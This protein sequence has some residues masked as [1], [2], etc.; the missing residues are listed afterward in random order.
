MKPFAGYQWNAASRGV[1]FASGKR[2]GSP[3]SNGLAFYCV[4]ELLEVSHGNPAISNDGSIITWEH[5]QA[6]ASNFI[7]A[8]SPEFDNMMATPGGRKV[9][10]VY[11]PTGKVICLGVMGATLS[12]E[13]LD[14]IE[15]RASTTDKGK[16]LE[17]AILLAGTQ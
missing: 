3:K 9:Y 15:G 2:E 1:L 13:Q 14:L 10:I 12:R 11:A 6:Y 17:S 8:V 4:G 16:Y 5:V 7:G